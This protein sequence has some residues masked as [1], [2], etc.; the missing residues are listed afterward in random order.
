MQHAEHEPQHNIEETLRLLQ[1]RP[2]LFL[3]EVTLERVNVWLGGFE[4]GCAALGVAIP[5]DVFTKVLQERGWKE[6]AYGQIPQMREKGLSDDQIVQ[7]LIE[8]QVALYQSV[9]ESDRTL[10]WPLMST[11][12]PRTAEDSSPSEAL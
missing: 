2:R 9:K 6:S 11:G 7:E 4:A 1:T 5:R 10:I 12:A 3:G 8:I